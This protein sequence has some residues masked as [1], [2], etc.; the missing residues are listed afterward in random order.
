ML[1]CIVLHYLT[2]SYMILHV[3]TYIHIYIYIYMIAIPCYVIPKLQAEGPRPSWLLKEDLLVVDAR[4]EV[5][6]GGE[7]RRAFRM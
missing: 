2:S 1:H 4:R 6:K 5:P 3:H 7:V